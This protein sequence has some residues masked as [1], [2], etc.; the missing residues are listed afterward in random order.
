[1]EPHPSISLKLEGDGAWPDLA[2]KGDQIR[3]FSNFSLACLSG[4]MGNEDATAK[5]PSLAIRVDLPDGQV[6]LIQ[7]SLRAWWTVTQA[8][9]ERYGQEI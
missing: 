7:T 4:G 9:M 5:R 8:I 2:D 3:E 1:M 6:V